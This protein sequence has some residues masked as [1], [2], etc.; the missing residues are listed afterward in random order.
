MYIIECLYMDETGVKHGSSFNTAS[1]FNILF[2]N[3]KFG[4]LPVGLVFVENDEEK[5]F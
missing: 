3:T 2:N 5:I 1:I 4:L